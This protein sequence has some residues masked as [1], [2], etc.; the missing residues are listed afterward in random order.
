MPHH[1]EVVVLSP[2]DLIQIIRDEIVPELL[3]ASEASHP[4]PALLS[5]HQLAQELGVSVSTVDRLRGQGM[6][7]VAILDARRFDIDD[8]LEWLKLREEEQ[9]G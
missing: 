6:P 9:D 8:V 1:P 4:S 5:R 7:S 2:S 3:A